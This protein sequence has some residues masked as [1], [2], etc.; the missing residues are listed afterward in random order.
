[1]L[2]WQCLTWSSSQTSTWS[3]PPSLDT[4]NHSND[5]SLP[6]VQRAELGTDCSGDDEYCIRENE[7]D[8]LLNGSTYSTTV[9][10]LL[11]IESLCVVGVVGNVIN[12]A[13]LSRRRMVSVLRGERASQTGLIGLAVSDLLAC[14]AKLLVAFVEG[15]RCKC[16]FIYFFISR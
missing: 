12:I 8:D 14:L 1:L 10:S 16:F 7:V 13:V 15:K 11:I 9:T 5:S 2:P 3:P 6:C 4:M